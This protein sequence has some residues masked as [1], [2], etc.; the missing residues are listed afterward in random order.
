MLLSMLFMAEQNSVVN[1]VIN[2]P[3]E[4]SYGIVTWQDNGKARSL[5]AKVA[6]CLIIYVLI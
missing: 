3:V 1:M 5:N 2:R 6:S 4:T